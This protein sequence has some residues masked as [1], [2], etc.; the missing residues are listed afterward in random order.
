MNIKTLMSTITKLARRRSDLERSC[1]RVGKMLSASLLLRAFPHRGDDSYASAQEKPY[2]RYWYLT[3]Y[4]G[5]TTRHRYIPKEKIDSLIPLV[6]NYG[7]FSKWM[8][9]IRSLN[10]CIVELLDKIGEIQCKEVEE[11][12]KRKRREG[13]GK[14]KTK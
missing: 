6:N 14:G 2:P 10:K 11:I 13:R 8:K 1:Q 7:K 9:E 12:G 4:D 3:Y 5:T